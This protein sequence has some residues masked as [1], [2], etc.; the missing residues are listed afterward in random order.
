MARV[1]HWLHILIDG[2]QAPGPDATPRA[3]AASLGLCEMSGRF[4]PPGRGRRALVGAHPC[5]RRIMDL[6]QHKLTLPPL[7]EDAGNVWNCV[8]MQGHQAQGHHGTTLQCKASGG[9]H[10]L[11]RLHVRSAQRG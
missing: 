9:L 8:R 5:L 4:A 11:C 3:A 2:V 7:R 10:D 1:Q 6:R